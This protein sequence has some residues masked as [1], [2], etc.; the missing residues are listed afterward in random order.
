MKKEYTI[1]P[2]EYKAKVREINDI[3]YRH[4]HFNRERGEYEL[5]NNVP[6]RVRNRFNKLRMEVEQTPRPKDKIFF[7]NEDLY[8]L[9]LNRD[10]DEPITARELYNIVLTIGREIESAE[11]R[12]VSSAT[13]N[14]YV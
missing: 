9:W 8:N 11:N 13:W 10:T 7:A 12:A 4:G 5:A 6:D 1:T 14:G 2:A 3:G